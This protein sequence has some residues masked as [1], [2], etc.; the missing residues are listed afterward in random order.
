MV[1]N[2]QDFVD[3]D[4]D[5]I[6]SLV[7][8]RIPQDDANLLIKSFGKLLAEIGVF[9]GKVVILEPNSWEDFPL[10]EDLEDL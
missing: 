3:Y 10:A 4:E 2:D 6:F 9:L 1:T 7:W 8:L 5:T